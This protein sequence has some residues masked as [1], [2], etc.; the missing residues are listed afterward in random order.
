MPFSRI[1]RLISAVLRVRGRFQ[2]PAPNPGTHQSP[3]E[4]LSELCG[5]LTCDFT[6]V[7]I[8][9]SLQDSGSSSFRGCC[10]ANVVVSSLAVVASAIFCL[11]MMGQVEKSSFHG[12]CHTWDFSGLS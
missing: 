5:F 1:F 8:S 10:L 2:K 3:V 11:S 9:R 12:R 6:V 4:T 7:C